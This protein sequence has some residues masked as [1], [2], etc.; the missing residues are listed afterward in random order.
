MSIEKTV[1]IT[2]ARSQLLKLTKLVARRMDR[3][4]LTNK[5][6]AEAVLVSVSEYKSL[7]AA[8]ELLARPDV[9]AA[10]RKGFEQI[11]AGKGVPLDQAFRR[12]K[13]CFSDDPAS[14]GF[15]QTGSDHRSGAPL[16]RMVEADPSER[17]TGCDIA[18]FSPTSLPILF[19]VT[20]S[21][22]SATDDVSR[23]TPDGFAFHYR[24]DGP[25]ICKIEFIGV[26]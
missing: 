10:T 17:R 6:E 13:T 14:E 26:Y 1:S 20:K 25:R 2:A 11:L 8:A 24:F 22:F 5:G 4:V 21:R 12:R 18:I 19:S 7:R 3:F 9:L 16:Q 15:D 23:S